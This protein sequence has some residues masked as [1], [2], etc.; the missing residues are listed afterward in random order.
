MSVSIKSYLN[1]KKAS[2]L[3]EDIK[4]YIKGYGNNYKAVSILRIA[5]KLL[6]KKEDVTVS[7]IEEVMRIIDNVY[8]EDNDNYTEKF[9]HYSKLVDCYL[10]YEDIDKLRKVAAIPFIAL[11]KLYR[12]ERLFYNHYMLITS[13]VDEGYID[14]IMKSEIFMYKNDIH[15]DVVG[16]CEF[17]SIVLD[18]INTHSKILI[19]KIAESNLVN[20][21]LSNN[22]YISEE[23]RH[24]YTK[25][26]KVFMDYLSKKIEYFKKDENGYV[27]LE[28]PK[29]VIVF[30]KQ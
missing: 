17:I 13:D 4:T 7:N 30:P 1:T 16:I 23:V 2:K 14:K 24:T 25:S 3:S 9:Y 15:R 27:L 26:A 6:K 20:D 19:K 5:Y 22:T 11:G 29:I 10:N 12:S 21:L 18:R 28:D 8:I